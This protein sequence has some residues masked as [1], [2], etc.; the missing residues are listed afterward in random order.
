[1]T[2]VDQAKLKAQITTEEGRKGKA[3]VDTVGKLTI[4]IGRNITDKGL[5]PDEIDY[6]YQNDFK[7][8]DAEIKSNLPWV[9]TLD[10][11]RQRV[12]YD[13]CFNMGM[14]RL[15]EF[16]FMLS[17]AKAG[18]FN[19]AADELHHSLWDSQVGNRAPKLEAMLRTGI[20]Q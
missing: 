5:S 18:D 12:F 15:L 2:T 13:L 16:H 1:M 11:V 7:E 19:T 17:Y 14:P 20:D 3:Y 9:L 6:L 4:A 10:E 8:V